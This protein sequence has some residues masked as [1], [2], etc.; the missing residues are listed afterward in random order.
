[1]AEMFVGTIH[2]FCL[3]LLKSES[4]KYLKY[5]VLNEV[6]QTLFVDRHSKASGLTQST[7]LSRTNTEALH[8]YPHFIAALN[9]LREDRPVAPDRLEGNTVVAQ[10]PRYEQL[11]HDRGYLDYSGILKE[12]VA[13]LK[14]NTGLRE[15]LAARIRHVIVDEY[16]DVNP[17]QEAVVEELHRLGAGI[18][19]VGDDDQTIYQW[20]G[21]DVRNILSFENRYPGVTQVRLEENFRSS[22]GVVAVAREFI[23]Q[24]VRRLPKEMK[25]TRAQE[26]EPGDITALPFDAPEDEARHIARTCQAL[27]GVA[28]REDGLERG[29][30]WSDMAILLRSV[31]RDGEAIMAALDEAGVPYVITGMD[32]LFQTDEA[33]AARQLFYF[34]AN[35]IDEADAARRLAGSRPGYR[36]RC[37]GP[38]GGCRRSCPAGHEAG[39]SR[40]VQGLQS[41]APVHR[42]PRERRPARG[43]G[44]W[45]SWRGGLLQP[46]QVQPGDLGFREHPLPLKP[47]RE[48]HKLRRLPAASRR[49]RLPGRLAGQ[50]VRQS[51]RGADHDRTPVQG[52]GVA[53]RLYPAARAQPLSVARRRGPNCLA[54]DPGSSLRQCRPL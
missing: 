16:Q 46:G 41:A 48:V 37:A 21:S 14:V 42:V 49:E 44:A 51:R 34:L 1:M 45:R 54:P 24:V 6:Q 4:P 30:S 52:A 43:T 35:E 23:R 40:A 27:R 26:Y 12:A 47:G 36:S 50:R 10:L 32:D 39:R 25:T 33:E 17:V 2:A 29:L 8:G 38:R 15:R 13:E 28:I 7:T 20:R 11:L 3:E 9:I 31:R 22:E 19:V 5:E 53:G 18:C